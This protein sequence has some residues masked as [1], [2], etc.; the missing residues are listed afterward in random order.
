MIFVG[1]DPG[2]KG[3]VVT[4]TEDRTIHSIKVMGDCAWFADHI[5][6]L[7]NEAPLKVYL[8]K[9]QAMPSNG[10]V[11]MFNYG[12]HYGELVG[13]LVTLCIPFEEIRPNTWT[14]EMHLQLKPKINPKVKALA[15]ANRLFPGIDLRNPE[16]TRA[17]VPHSGIVDALLIAEYGRRKCLMKTL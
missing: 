15:A 12:K 1:I 5:N 6:E 14:R 10:A 4:L 9:A 2:I 11:S 3:A 17:T 16:S 8:E 13:V 7:Q